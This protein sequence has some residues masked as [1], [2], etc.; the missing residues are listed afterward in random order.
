MWRINGDHLQS[1][2]QQSATFASSYSAFRKG[3]VL[4]LPGLFSCGEG[5]DALFS[6]MLK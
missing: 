5:K 2:P 1:N 6:E 3:G 4:V